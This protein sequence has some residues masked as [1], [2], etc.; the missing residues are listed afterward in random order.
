MSENDKQQQ[1]AEEPRSAPPA[2]A[3]SGGV[4]VDMLMIGLILIGLGALLLAATMNPDLNFRDL[5]MT[6]WPVLII[7][8]GLVKIVQAA[9]GISGG[10]S[11]FG[12]LVTVI[13]I[14]I[15]VAGVP[16]DWVEFNSWFAFGPDAEYSEQINLA[17]GETLEIRNV[18][19][20]ARIYSH[21][22]D[23]VKLHVKT[24]VSGWSRKDARELAE[25][26]KAE[27]KRT[28][29]TVQIVADAESASDGRRRVRVDLEIGLPRD[30]V[31][32]IS[33]H[34]GDVDLDNFDGEMDIDV[35]YGDVD[36]A[37]STGKLTISIR[38]GEVDFYDFTGDLKV[39]GGRAAL[40]LEGVYGAIFVDI[41]RGS[42]ELENYKPIAGDIDIHTERGNIELDINGDSDFALEAEAQGGRID[43][44]FGELDISNQR[45]LRH[46]FNAGTYQVSLATDRGSIALDSD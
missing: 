28:G 20:D 7:V 19:A 10:G 23:D 30:L 41:E 5:V 37:R 43:C 16:W 1:P 27:V 42:I 9:L 21:S 40:D 13:I 29:S 31:A 35:E 14:L 44:E 26:Y 15:L 33:A 24:Y 46:S 39:T 38:N 12:L 3:K 22:G 6:Y 17:E 11:G 18:R 2:P 45:E 34:R 36:V 32:R 8:A 4:R 25:A